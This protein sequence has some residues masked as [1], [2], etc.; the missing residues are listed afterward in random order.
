MV[1]KVNTLRKIVVTGANKGIGFEIVRQLAELETPYHI[2]LTSRNVERGKAALGQIKKL[3]PGSKLEYQQLDVSDSQSI[4]TFV[5]W[6]KEAL[7]EIDVLVNNA[8]FGWQKNTPEQGLEALK[9]NFLGAVELTEKILPFLSSDGKIINVTSESGQLCY[10]GD[11][12]RKALSDSKLDRK[13][14]FEI[15]EEYQKRI[16]DKT[17][18]Q[19]GWYRG[20]YNNT[21]CLLNA[22]TRWV[23]PNLLKDEQSCYCLDPGYCKTDMA[24]EGPLHVSEGAKTPI[25][26]IKLPFKKNPK[27]NGQFFM[28]GKVSEY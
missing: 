4:D 28:Y 20:H 10:Q 3:T 7:G 11:K 24:P 9:T 19:L 14:L 5:S 22:Y 8:G 18:T 6:V 21:K 13:R 12:I 17:Y 26:L 1:D 2:I 27:Y 16:F 15:V 25:Y 23:L